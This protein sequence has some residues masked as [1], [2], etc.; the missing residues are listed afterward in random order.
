MSTSKDDNNTSSED[1]K[2][3]IGD[4]VTSFKEKGKAILDDI[5]ESGS[6]IGSLYADKYKNQYLQFPKNIE[7][8]EEN[9]WIRF[10]VQELSGFKIKKQP[11]RTLVGDVGGESFIGDL[12]ASGVEKAT[13]LARTAIQ[14]P[15]NIAKGVTNEFLSDLPPGLSD[16]GRKFLDPD[17][18]LTEG[19][20]SIVLYAPASQQIS[21]N[22]QWANQPASVGG[23]GMQ[24]FAEGQGIKN[25]ETIKGLVSSFGRVAIGQGG[26]SAG[27]ALGAGSA[28]GQET[29]LR[30]LGVAYNNHLTAF[31]QGVSFRSVQF[32]FTLAPRNPSEAR[33]IQQI[34]RLFKYAA[35]PAMVDGEYGP[36][37]A[38]PNVF[39]IQL[40]NEDETQKYL[41][42]ALTDITVDYSP[43]GQ[44]TTFYD[45]FPA[46]VN[47][48]LSFTELAIINKDRVDEGY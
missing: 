39:D 32:Q 22:F 20:G 11:S 5:V 16:I 38:Y 3:K 15:I 40:H 21:T 7:S 29:L 42:S 1:L 13:A 19:L 37:F 43:A 33:E 47:L 17:G 34:V 24:A 8:A 4:G 14:A 30:G 27:T 2:G 35:A 41:Q 45:K 31:F 23:A 25:N 44:N 10:D 12:V 6:P 48:T 26:A 28:A 36:F 46:A 18:Q 9:T